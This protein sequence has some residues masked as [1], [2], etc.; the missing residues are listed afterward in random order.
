MMSL[1][2]LILMIFFGWNGKVRGVVNYKFGIE[3]TLLTLGFMPGLAALL[4]GLL[5]KYMSG[6]EGLAAFISVFVA[7]LFV[8]LLLTYILGKITKIPEYEYTPADRGLGFFVGMFKGFCIAGLLIMLY[9]VTF[10]DSVAPQGLTN[11]MKKNF[12]NITVNEPIDF[13]RS[14]VYSLYKKTSKASVE[15]LYA[16]KEKLLEETKVVGYVPWTEGYVYVPP[17]EKTEEEEGGIKLEPEEANLTDM[18]SFK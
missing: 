8:F 12:V 1:I 4:K 2:T 7:T 17:K 14:T 13:Y 3:K 10:I 5:L 11:M 18:N 6:M 16:S 9:G 15:D